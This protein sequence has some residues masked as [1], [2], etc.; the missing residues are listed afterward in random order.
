M[1]RTRWAL[2]K[3]WSVSEGNLK[4]LQAVP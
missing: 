4:I 2:M 1:D 3:I